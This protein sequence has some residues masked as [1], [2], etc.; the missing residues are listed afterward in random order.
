MNH[1]HYV[2]SK[3]IKG[4]RITYA[5]IF[6]VGVF[7]VFTTLFSSFLSKVLVDALTHQLEEAELIERLV[8]ILLTR[9]SGPE[10][11]YQHLELLPVTLVFSS[12]ATAFLF[13]VRVYLRAY[14]A[15][16]INYNLQTSLHEHLQ[17]LPYETFKKEKEGDLIQTCTRDIDLVRRFMVMRMSQM[18]YTVT[19]FIFCFIVLTEINFKLALVSFATIPFLFI[20][21]YFMI[22]LVRYRYRKTDDSEADVVDAIS[23]NLNGVRI[24][25]AFN[26]EANEIDS[27]SK[28]L[29][30]Y[31][32]CY[33][34]HTIA[35]AFFYSSSD[36]FI[37]LARSLALIY[38]IY[39]AYIKEITAGT[40]FISYTF[41]NM[42]VWPLRDMATT[43][44][45]LGQTLASADRIHLLLSLPVEDR[46]KG[47]SLQIK[48]EIEFN[49]V[50]FAYPDEHDVA[51]LQDVSFHIKQGQT[52]AILG[53][54]GS[55]KST[56][57]HLLCHLYDDYEGEIKID[58]V[59][60]REY[61][62][63]SLRRQILPV[64]QDPFL[65]SMSLQENVEVA[66]SSPA[67][68]EVERAVMIAGLT[69][70]LESFPE[71]YQTRVGEKG[72]TLS[73]GQRQRIAIARALL[74]HPPILLLDDSLS[75]V[76]MATDQMI[77]ENL[78]K[79]KG[80]QTTLLITH[81]IASAKDADM[82]LVLDKGSIVE[83]G[84]HEELLS[85]HGL[86]AQ[87]ASIQNQVKGG[88][89]HG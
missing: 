70:T 14:S 4:A 72:V 6:I 48:G 83:S 88:D 22:K 64:L 2:F 20:Y 7:A 34:K 86:Y 74:A 47:K 44:S 49:H 46:E 58:G 13:W 61:S 63:H 18:T 28:S 55:G 8:I 84:T 25:K 31:G 78:A 65:F 75:A 89:I 82:I 57:F 69:S 80:K 35:S 87:I 9:N 71:G 33:K 10:Y 39:L 60:I 15:S 41:V 66:T 24:V 62:L 43:L 68:Q 67:F 1:L 54:T 17:S 5:S 40:V 50:N 81:R 51:I 37:F 30:I 76:D 16:R 85:N 23:Q 56:L 27:F 3:S 73:G 79:E 29:A 12:L 21:S 26:E 45:N 36:I 38:A 32:N 59:D 53:K 52:V 77:R 19:M 42:M 11:L